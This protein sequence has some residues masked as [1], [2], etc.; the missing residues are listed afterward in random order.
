MDYEFF[1]AVPEYEPKDEVFIHVYDYD[2]KEVV[3]KKGRVL[4]PILVEGSPHPQYLIKVL[5][6]RFIQLECRDAFLISKTEDGLSI[7][8][9]PWMVGARD[10]TVKTS[11]KN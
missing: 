4:A 3:V 6:P 1:E 11:D 9:P 2:Q 8:W 10:T 5:D 7:V